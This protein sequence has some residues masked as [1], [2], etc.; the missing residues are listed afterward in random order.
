MHLR[1]HT[2]VQWAQHSTLTVFCGQV[3]PNY[4]WLLKFRSH[5]APRRLASVVIIKSHSEAIP[6]ALR[7][8]TSKT[9]VGVSSKSPIPLAPQQRATHLLHA[10][11]EVGGR[12]RAVGIQLEQVIHI[13]ISACREPDIQACI[14]YHQH[15]LA[16]C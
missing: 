11:W 15:A 3:V 9:L 2:G 5:V 12:H 13:L 1:Q 6:E 4:L 10:R 8:V 14:S 16:I 7:D